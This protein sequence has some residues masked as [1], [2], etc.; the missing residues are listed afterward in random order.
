M[1]E[2]Q[3]SENKI[4]INEIKN[5]Y[6]EVLDDSTKYLFLTRDSKLQEEQVKQLT[7]FRDKIKIYKYQIIQNGHEELANTFFHFQCVIN[8]HISLLLMWINLKKK[9]YLEAWNNLIESEKY[10]EYALRINGNHF[11]IVEFQERLNDIERVVFP[12]FPLYNSPGLIISG[13]QC[14]I[15][16][17]PM[18]KCDH[19]E[20]MIYWGRV[21]KRINPKLVSLDHSALVEVPKDKRCIIAEFTTDDGY[22]QDYFTWE[23]KNRVEP[24]KKKDRI[25]KSIIF[26]NNQLDLF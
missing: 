5:R 16:G 13:G 7:K 18:D 26:N 23:K 20:E 3:N 24:S 9:K 21:C 1:S 10:I 11:G 6:N 17:A 2:P 15:C 22:Y 25:F 19:I 12:G 4:T 14:S 8:G